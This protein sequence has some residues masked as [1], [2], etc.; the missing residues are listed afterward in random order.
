MQLVES[1]VFAQDGEKVWHHSDP[2]GLEL[3]ISARDTVWWLTTVEMTLS[4]QQEAPLFS[5]DGSMFYVTLPAAQGG[6][7][8]YRHI[9]VL[10]TQV[11]VAFQPYLIALSY[12]AQVSLFWM[13]RVFSSLASFTMT[14]SSAFKSLSPSLL[15]GLYR[16]VLSLSLSLSNSISLSLQPL[17]TPMSPRFLTSGQWDVMSLCG[18]DEDAEKM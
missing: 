9:A 12:L 17:T 14:P 16:C 18:L 10:P 5:R 4:G 1:A 6:H 15:H 8:E 3:S 11:R 7:G 2:Q 13:A